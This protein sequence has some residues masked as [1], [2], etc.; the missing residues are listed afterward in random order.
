MHAQP[1]LT[2]KHS[3]L[4]IIAITGLKHKMQGSIVFFLQ[5]MSFFRYA[6]LVCISTLNASISVSLFSAGYFVCL[7]MHLHVLGHDD[8]LLELEC[9]REVV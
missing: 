6:R 2:L 4:P 1:S 5:F 7:L 9:I 3:L 8:G